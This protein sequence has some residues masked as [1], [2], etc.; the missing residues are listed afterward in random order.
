VTLEEF[1]DTR[2]LPQNWLE[3]RKECEQLVRRSDFW[4][5]P[6]LKDEAR[7]LASQASDM[8]SKIFKAPSEH[9]ER[10]KRHVS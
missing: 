6:E 4:Y 1:A 5:R 10:R 9:E 8:L 7:G 2:H 3:L